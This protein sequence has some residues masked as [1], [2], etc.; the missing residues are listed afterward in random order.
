MVPRRLQSALAAQIERRRQGHQRDLARGVAYVALPHA[1][2][3]KYPNAGREL[4]WQFL[5]AS[6]QLSRDP[7]TGRVGRHHL[8]SATRTWPPR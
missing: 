8:H 1:L 7:P 4:G 2:A 6:R 5:F 3:R